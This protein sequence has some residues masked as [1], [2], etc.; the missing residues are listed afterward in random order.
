MADFSNHR[1]FSLRCLRKDLIPVSIRLRSNIKTPK[2][3]HIIW[4]AERA[5][6]NERIQSINNTLNMLEIQRDTCK[7]QKRHLIER[8]LKNVKILLRP[9]ERLNT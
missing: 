6:L 9:R 1:R 5:L 8:A 3:Y 7:N 2:G 4:K